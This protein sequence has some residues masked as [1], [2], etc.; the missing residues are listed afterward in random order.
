[1][2]NPDQLLELLKQTE[3]TWTSRQVADHFGW[4]IHY[5]SDLVSRAAVKKHDGF[6]VVLNKIDNVKHIHISSCN[7]TKLER[8][9]MMKRKFI[10]GQ[11]NQITGQ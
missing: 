7:T 5:T 9:T 11:Y 8:F 2:T 3:R 4:D 1:M 6:M 10:F